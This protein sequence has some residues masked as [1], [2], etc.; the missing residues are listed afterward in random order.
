METD[1]DDVSTAT[2]IGESTGD[3]LV[4]N[5]NIQMNVNENEKI[6]IQTTNPTTSEIPPA[7]I[8]PETEQ[9]S[10]IQE[11]QIPPVNVLIDD[12]LEFHTR[13]G[14]LVRLSNG[15]RT[16]ERRRPFDEFNNGVVMTHRPL[17]DD[18]LFEVI[19]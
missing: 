10:I 11:E 14:S 1:A 4:T 17:H 8:D 2:T 12:R 18:E 9:Q 6:A 19:I 7:Q 5:L 16:A 15:N 13:C 3:Q